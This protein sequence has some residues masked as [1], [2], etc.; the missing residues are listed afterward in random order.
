MAG[1]RVGWLQALWIPVVGVV[2]ALAIWVCDRVLVTGAPH[3]SW[4]RDL[5][6][7]FF[8]CYS[9]CPNHPQSSFPL[10]LGTELVSH[11]LHHFAAEEMG[12]KSHSTL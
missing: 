11:S 1:D 6:S 9:L 2:M 3:Q 8:S 4:S 7:L 10:R 5:S 12:K